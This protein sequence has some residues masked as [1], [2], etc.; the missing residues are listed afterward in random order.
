MSIIRHLRIGVWIAVATTAIVVLVVKAETVISYAFTDRGGVSLI[1]RG[2][3]NPSTIGFARIQPNNQN[4]TPAGLAVFGFRAGGV[5]ASEAGVPASPLIQAGRIYA[6]VNGPV[7]TG[8]AIANPNAQTATISFYFTNSNGVDFGAGTKTIPPN[9][10]F[11][12]FLNEPP[13]NSG[14]PISGTLTFTASL[15]VSVIALRGF[16]NERSEFLITTLP[17]TV[18]AAGSPGTVIFP[19]FADGGG[20]TTQLVL[21]NP[22]DSVLS[23]TVQFFSSGSGGTAGQPMPIDVNG[24]TGTTFNYTVQRQSSTR[25]VTA[26]ASSA[27]SSGSIRVVPGSNQVAPSGLVIFSYKSGGFTVSE[28]SVIALRPSTAFRL[29]AEASNAPSSILSGVAVANPSSSPTNVS[30]ELMSLTGGTPILTGSV[31]IPANGQLARFLNQIQG[32]DSLPQPFKGVLRI[33]SAA[34][35]A[36]V[37][38][39]SRVN[40]RGD[41]LIT[42]TPPSDETVAPSTTDTFFP[43]FVDSGGYTTQFILFSGSAGQQS[44]GLIRTFGQNG[45]PLDLSLAGL[46]DLAV[47]QTDSPDPVS[48]G[49]PL[50]YSIAITN[51]GPAEATGVVVADILP[52]AA[53]FESAVPTQGTCPAQPTAG[54]LVCNLGE[55]R[56]GGSASVTITVR[57]PAAATLVNTVSVAGNEDDSIPA[58]NRAVATTVV[59][60]ATDLEITQT[61]LQTCALGQAPSIPTGGSCDAVPYSITVVNKGPAAAPNVTVTD[62]LPTDPPSGIIVAQRVSVSA[63]QGTCGGVTI[64]RFTC[65]LGL[66]AVGGA[67]SVNVVFAID[68]TA[69]GR[70]ITNRV[71]VGSPDVVDPVSS[72]DST[73]IPDLQVTPGPPAETDVEVGTNGNLEW[74]PAVLTRPGS[75]TLRVRLRNRGP[76]TATNV[77]VATTFSNFTGT[78]SLQSVTTTQGTC[79]TQGATVTCTVGT[80]IRNVERTITMVL[81]PSNA[82]QV[83]ATATA[84]STSSAQEEDTNAGNNQAALTLTVN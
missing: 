57:P 22:G 10:Q 41:F 68:P 1:T 42:T 38:L 16:S 40:E 54:V 51:S 49:S 32:L 35:I 20:W 77:R 30:I 24:Q 63:S 74:T 15:P 8:I 43:H 4:T 28:A 71:L 55:L 37:G 58:N 11:A 72:N 62:F 47:T 14:S 60:A 19:H 6:E 5:L 17:V 56:A 34:P 83:V 65:N 3:T 44:S 9:S 7:N 76:S 33:A 70:R 78:L 18:P 80:L 69:L 81:V 31:T 27:I 46:A 67:A 2:G 52:S 29:Y 66:L 36:V 75:A 73:T 50:T 21:V 82:G 13:F 12:A 59:A 45:Q 25:L 64:D 61:G 48:P 84:T 53:A 23:G 26:G 39:R 79:S